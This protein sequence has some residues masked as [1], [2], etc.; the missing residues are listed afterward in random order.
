MDTR[1]ILNSLYE[2]LGGEFLQER[3]KDKRISR[4][5]KLLK[6]L[7]VEVEIKKHVA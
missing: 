2:E 1:L 3:N 7:G 4:H 5:L 6:E